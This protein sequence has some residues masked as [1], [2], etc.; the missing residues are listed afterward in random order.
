M[1]ERFAKHLDLI[2]YQIYPRSFCDSNGDGIGDLRGVISKLDYLSELGVNAIWLCPCYKSPNVDNGY[3]IAD[4]RDI[5]DE[6]GTLDDMKALIA[7]LHARGMK[8]IMDL[9]PNHTSDRHR[10]FVESRKSKDNPYSDYYYWFDTPPNDWQ[11][12]FEGSAWQYDEGRGQY[13]LHSY[14][15]GQPD[16]NWENPAVVREMQA[17]V[18]FWVGLGVDGFRI[19]VIDQISKDW[20]RNQNIFGPH[21]HEYIKSLFGRDNV[22]HL[23]T[24]GECW[25]VEADEIL[26]HCREE[27]NELVTLFQFDHLNA[28]RKSGKWFPADND[29]HRFVRDTLVKW[30]AFT[31]ENDII[32]SLFTDNHDQNYFLSR[33][34]DTEHYRYE[35]A[36]MLAAMFYLLKG[37]PFIY[38]GQEFGSIG[39]EYDSMDDYDDVESHNYYNFRIGKAGQTHEKLMREINFGSRDNARRPVAWNGDKYNG[40]STVRPWITPATY[41]GD[42]NL[43]R[44]RV[45]KKSVFE[46]YRRVLALRRESDAI[47]RGTLAV[48]N[49]PEDNFFVYRRALGD[50]RYVVICNFDTPSH[51]A[52]PDGELVLSNYGRVGDESFRPYETAVYRV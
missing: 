30:Q 41:A 14:A 17:V 52:V 39:S 49:R 45:S 5:M 34:G 11:S 51:I 44:D 21:L 25:G 43:E 46:F 42:I 48:L 29:K 23:F 50:E 18:D 19:D 37:V 3:D 16:L 32:H 4:Y 38:Q 40:F 35:S 13:Y 20:E 36:T 12:S 27:R 2:V 8:L 9:V 1:T 22:R 28:G 15:V 47:R 24:V 26:R 33:V 6:F 10:W 31:A 7:E